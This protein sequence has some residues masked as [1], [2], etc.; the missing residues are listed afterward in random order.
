MYTFC[1]SG[2]IDHGKSTLSGHLLYKCNYIDQRELEKLKN[3]AKTNN[4]VGSEFA[5]ILDETN[6]EKEKGITHDYNKIEFQREDDK[7]CLIDTPGHKQ[8]IRSLIAGLNSGKIK[9]GCLVVSAVENEFLAGMGN[10]QIKEDIILMRSVGLENIIVLINKMDKYDYNQDIFID[11]KN[12]INEFIKK[13]GFKKLEYLMISGY[14]GY[15]L[16]LLLDKIKEI[17]PPEQDL[18]DIEDCKETFDII[19]TQVKILETKTLISAGYQAIIHVGM[20]EYQIVIEELVNVDSQTKKV[21]NFA[22]NG[23]VVQMKLKRLDNEK[24]S[25]SKKDRIIFRHHDETIGFGKLK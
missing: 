20:E 6:E 24:I 13:L 25:I 14:T 15:N 18:N 11:R 12:K 7:Y 17:Y 2:H 21:K 5:F 10:G 23:D 3:E 19:N 22:K 1:I 16:D 9:V 8:F 4:H